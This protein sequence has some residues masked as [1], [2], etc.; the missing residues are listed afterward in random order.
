MSSSTSR[1]VVV[2][3]PLV[4]IAHWGLVIAFA[5]AYLTE[6]ELLTVHVWAGYTVGAI[7]VIRVIWGLVGPRHARFANFLTSPGKVVAYLRDLVLFRSRRYLGHSPAG[8]AMTIALL[9]ALAVTVTTGLMGFGEAKHAGPL[10]FL[11]PVPAAQE[12]TSAENGTALFPSLDDEDEAAE[13]GE[14]EDGPGRREKPAVLELHETLANLTLLLVILH[15]GGV[16][17]ASFAHRENLARAMVTGRK[18]AD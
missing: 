12:G 15:I 11:Y 8:G 14:R 3:D 5:I 1:D 9:I 17:L 10:A 7:V 18:R 2:W 4:R 13:S 6:G 16:A